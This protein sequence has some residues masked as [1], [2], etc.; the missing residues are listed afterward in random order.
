[1]LLAA[2]GGMAGC[3]P[4]RHQSEFAL[5]LLAGVAGSTAWRVAADSFKTRKRPGR[6]AGAGV[7]LEFDSMKKRPAKKCCE[8]SDKSQ[9]SELL[10]LPDGQV[11]V[12]NL[13]PTFAGLLAGLNPDCEQITLRLT[14]H[15]STK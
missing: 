9:V 11:L 5:G 8:S 3:K 2:G 14:A 1:M 4:A 15:A 6:R 7:R 12:H 13:T 10:I